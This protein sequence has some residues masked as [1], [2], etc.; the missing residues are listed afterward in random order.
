MYLVETLSAFLTYFKETWSPGLFTAG[1]SHET[2]KS[3]PHWV[4]IYDSVL[5]AYSFPDDLGNFSVAILPLES[6]AK[7]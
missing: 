2:G 6:R 5:L 1:G 7:G 3:R 4:S